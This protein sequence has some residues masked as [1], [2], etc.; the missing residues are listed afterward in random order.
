MQLIDAL[1]KRSDAVKLIESVVQIEASCEYDAGWWIILDGGGY[2]IT[3]DAFDTLLNLLRIP[4]KYI[5]RCMEEDGRFLA[6]SSVN[7]WLKKYGDLSFLVGQVDGFAEYA[8]TQVFPGKRLYLPGEQVNDLIIDYLQGDVIVYSFLVADDVFNA[9]YLT[10]ERVVVD[11]REVSLGVS[12]L[13]SD[14]FN[15]TPRFDGVLVSEDNSTLGWPTIGRKFRVASNTIT[16]V[17]DQIEEF[18]DLSIAG[19]NNTLIPALAEFSEDHCTLIDAENFFTRLCNDL[20]LS[21]KVKDEL[22]RNCTQYPNHMPSELVWNT[23][24][25]LSESYWSNIDMGMA[26]DIQIAISYYVVSGNFKG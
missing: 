1:D 14:C 18:L 23:A 5:K 24:K 10:D 21:K 6:E 4:I 16:Q 20:R 26:R 2:P 7:Y 17:I 9:T 25:Y 13:Y 11:G 12:V 8:I 15:I 22:I 19:L 3:D